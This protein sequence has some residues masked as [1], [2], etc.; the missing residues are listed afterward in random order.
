MAAVVM[1]YWIEAFAVNDLHDNGA[2]VTKVS[3]QVRTQL[4]QAL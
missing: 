4:Q 1:G 3:F 2:G